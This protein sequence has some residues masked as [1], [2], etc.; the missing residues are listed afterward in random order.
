MHAVIFANTHGES[1]NQI[2]AA[3]AASLAIAHEFVR[4]Q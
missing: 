3:T 1:A 2:A 4:V